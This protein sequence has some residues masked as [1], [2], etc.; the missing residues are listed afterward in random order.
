MT[1]CVCLGENNL[2]VNLTWCLFF[3]NDSFFYELYKIDFNKVSEVRLENIN[4]CRKYR[5][6]SYLLT[7]KQIKINFNKVGQE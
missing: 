4:E 5:K 6:I 7:K 1:W 3:I 2:V